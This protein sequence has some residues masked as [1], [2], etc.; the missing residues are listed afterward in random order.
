MPERPFLQTNDYKERS[1]P[2]WNL[3]KELA[4]QGKLTPVQAVLAAPHMPA[5]ELYDLDTDPYEIQNLAESSEPEHQ[6]VLKRLR[7][8]LERWIDESNDQGRT[9]EP[10][11]VAAAKGATR[12]VPGAS[13]TANAKAKTNAAAKKKARTQDGQD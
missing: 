8:E 2:V 6:A 5:E 10:L 11:G 4:A 7:A 13:P 12:P 1:Y 9:P 3:I